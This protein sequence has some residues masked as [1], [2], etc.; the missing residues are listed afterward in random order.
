MK[1][2]LLVWMLA[3][4]ALAEAPADADAENVKPVP[5]VP[6][7]DHEGTALLLPNLPH[8]T[9]ILRIPETGPATVEAAGTVT[10]VGPSPPPPGPG[11][12]P[13]LSDRAKAIKAAADKA[14]GDAKRAETAQG[15]AALYREIASNAKA[16]AT[17]ET[18]SSTTLTMT[19]FLTLHQA[20]T[21]AWAPMREV[22]R[23]QLVDAIQKGNNGGPVTVE[24]L[25]T[26]LNE[27]ADGLEAS[28]PKQAGATVYKTPAG[29]SVSG[30]S[31]EFWAFLIE[32]LKMLLPLLIPK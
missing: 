10:L 31:P 23:G 1:T 21:A 20:S 9:Y 8:G 13:A 14:T 7:G 4:V 17:A 22:L 28:A 30:I 27:A 25:G 29:N 11:P 5:A 3:G 15:L 24:Q 32:L 19:D 18:V 26:L 12:T 6:K 16:P 2:L